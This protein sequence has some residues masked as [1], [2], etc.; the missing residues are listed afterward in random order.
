M[1]RL[2]LDFCVDDEVYFDYM[3]RKYDVDGE[4]LSIPEMEKSSSESCKRQI[5]QI[6]TEIKAYYKMRN[7]DNESY[8]KNHID[9]KAYF[10]DVKALFDDLAP[11]RERLDNS[12]IEAIEKQNKRLRGA[13][14]QDAVTLIKADFIKEKSVY[15]VKLQELRTRAYKKLEEIKDAYSTFVS[16]KYEPNAKEMD[17]ECVNLL[18]SGIKFSKSEIESLIKKYE[19]NNTMLRIVSDYART[20]HIATDKLVDVT[21]NKVKMKRENQLFDRLEE[22]FRLSFDFGNQEVSTSA[23]INRKHFE[24]KYNEFVEMLAE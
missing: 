7:I 24:R 17:T 6:R 20:N 3:G 16:G 11:E 23:K 13:K 22:I 2:L 18:N 19:G 5:E 1:N 21:V 8:A 12:I 10:E 9:S 15:E 14:S 4:M